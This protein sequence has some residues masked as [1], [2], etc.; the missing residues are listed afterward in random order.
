MSILTVK[1]QFAKVV[2]V[3]QLVELRGWP[4]IAVRREQPANFGWLY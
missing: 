2:L 3:V 1:S 4:G